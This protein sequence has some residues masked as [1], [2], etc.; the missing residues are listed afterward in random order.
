MT[1]APAAGGNGV[2]AFGSDYR[3]ERRQTPSLS[4]ALRREKPPTA[5]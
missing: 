1:T 3:N 5:A 4:L 2:V